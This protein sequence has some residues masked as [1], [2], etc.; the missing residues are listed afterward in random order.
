MD[1]RER[2]SKD[3]KEISLGLGADLVGIAGTQEINSHPPDPNWPQ[4]PKNIWEECLSVIVLGKRIPVGMFRSRN[5]PTKQYDPHIIM[6]R[7]DQIALDLSYFLE[8][9]GFHSFPIPQQHTDINLKKGTY[10][11]LSLRHCAVEAGLGTLGLNLNFL[12]P[13]YGPRVYLTAV[14]TDADLVPDERMEK[15]LCL[16]AVCGRCLLACPPDAVLHWNLD[17]RRCSTHA[18]EWWI[19]SLFK[20][21]EKIL[22]AETD[23]EKKKL[24]H[25]MDTV[26]FWQ[27]LRNGPGAY[28]GCPRCLEVCPVGED[29]PHIKDVHER[30]P[31]ETQEKKERLKKMREAE[32]K[33]QEIPSF[34]FSRRWIGKIKEV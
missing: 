21:L 33:G 2:Y 4:T 17:K 13:K 22:E 30:I 26:A 29:Y 18:Q 24:I 28:G 32:R 15:S 19:A 27:A 12:S 6:N 7:L 23:E 5:L 11:P 34:Q 25:S 9:K 14:L 20:H 8:E 1:N 10:G 16:G 3:V 31:E